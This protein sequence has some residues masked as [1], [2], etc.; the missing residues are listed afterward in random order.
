M[1]NAKQLYKYCAENK[2]QESN[3]AE[4]FDQ[5]VTLQ[6]KI[7]LAWWRSKRSCCYKESLQKLLSEPFLT[8]D[9]TL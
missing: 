6:I 9:R 5:P 2:I 8:K 1:P 3:T 4:N 7:A